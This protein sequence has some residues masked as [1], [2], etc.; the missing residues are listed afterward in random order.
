MTDALHAVRRMVSRTARR[1]GATAGIVV[2]TAVRPAP[3]GWHNL[4]RSTQRRFET[5]GLGRGLRPR[6]PAMARRLFEKEVPAAIRRMGEPT[7]RDWMRGQHF[8]HDRSVANAPGRARA[9]SNVLLE[10]AR[11]NLSRGS[12]NMTAAARA[13][14]QSAGRAAAIRTGARTAVRAGAKAGLIAAAMEAPVTVT[15]NVLHCK[16]GRKSR[17]QA[18]RDAVKSIATAGCAGV[19]TGVVATGAAAVGLSLGPFG[20]PLMVA[21]GVV[22]A[23][24]ATYRIANAARRTTVQTVT[25]QT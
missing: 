25:V 8:S 20:V 3:A 9:P 14:A 15:E 19:A 23:G 5:G 17:G 7:L 6:T 10:N 22:F 11:D 1:G 2:G 13:A 4:S 12:R 24:S 18:T 16:R 21:G